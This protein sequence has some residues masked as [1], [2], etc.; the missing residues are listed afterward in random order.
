[1]V[2]RDR[3]G[4]VGVVVG[5]WDCRRGRNDLSFCL[6]LLYMG[7]CGY[8]IIFELLFLFKLETVIF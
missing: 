8:F 4:W 2:E 7:Y 3:G 1:V 5:D 6:S